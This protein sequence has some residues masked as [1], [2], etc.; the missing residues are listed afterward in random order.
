MSNKILIAIGTIL[1]L[2]GIFFTLGSI[3][4]IEQAFIGD[5]SVPTNAT[6]NGTWLIVGVILLIVG[7]ILVIIGSKR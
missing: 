2:I 7:L 4:Q 1:L 6:I 3:P 5:S